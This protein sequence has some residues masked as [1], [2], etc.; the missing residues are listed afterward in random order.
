M[1]IYVSDGCLIG[2]VYDYY[3]SLALAYLSI[4][5]HAFEVVRACSVKYLELHSFIF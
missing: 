5:N 2:D 1:G 4:S 3:V